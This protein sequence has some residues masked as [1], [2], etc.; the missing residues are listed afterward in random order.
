MIRNLI[1]FMSILVVLP[2]LASFDEII[3]EQN[4]YAIFRSPEGI[5]FASYVEQ[6]DESML[7]ELYS[8]LKKNKHGEEILLLQEVTVKG[9]NNQAYGVYNALKSTI[10]LFNGHKITNPLQY[11]DTLAHEYGHH[12]AYYY[13]KNHHLPNS[14]YVKLRGL[15]NTAVRFDAFWNYKNRN[16]MW[17]VQEIM[18][19]DY[20]LLYGA[21][22]S[23]NLEDV[24][25]NE[26]FYIKSS[27]ENKYIANVLENEKLHQYFEDRTGLTVESSR[28]TKI[29]VL[30]HISQDGLIFSITSKPH[31]VAY[32]IILQDRAGQTV[33]ELLQVVQNQDTLKFFE[34]TDDNVSQYF[35]EVVDLQTSIGFQTI[36]QVI[37]R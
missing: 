33:N 10:T 11:R 18:A 26:A 17:Y 34:Y 30:K 24:Y 14:E 25:N 35:F 22:E 37:K 27:H 2:I 21:T 15:K 32:K 31:S 8:I 7:K 4:Y 9:E 36:P 19:D 5:V 13:F 16:H 29:P 20:V 6:W 23:L 1:V 3:S 28:T 12:F